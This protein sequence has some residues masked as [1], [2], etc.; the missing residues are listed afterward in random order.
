MVTQILVVYVIDDAFLVTSVLTTQGALLL[1]WP[2]RN[3]FQFYNIDMLLWKHC[4]YLCM[5]SSRTRILLCIC[6]AFEISLFCYI[7]TNVASAELKKGIQNF[8]HAYVS[9]W[10]MCE[11]IIYFMN[12]NNLSKTHEHKRQ[13]WGVWV[14]CS[15]TCCRQ[16]KFNCWIYL[17]LK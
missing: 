1:R 11:L 15:P 17:Q 9:S 10:P 7:F 5:H 4:R 8:Q 14:M 12:A 2:K 16:I 6:K 13:N 3:S